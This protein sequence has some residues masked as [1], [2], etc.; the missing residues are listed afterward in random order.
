MFTQGDNQTIAKSSPKISLRGIR[1]EYTKPP[2]MAVR[3]VS[4]DVADGEF[5]AIVGESGSGKSTLVKT[6][7]RLVEPTSGDVLLDGSPASS[8]PVHKL[9]RSIGYMLQGV[10]LFPHYNIFQNI[11]VVLTL[12]KW[13]KSKLEHRVFDVMRLVGLEPEVY[14]HRF[15]KELSGGQQQRAGFAR[16]IAAR[17][18]ILLMDEPLGAIDPVTRSDLQVELHQLHRQLCLTSI[19]VTH[20]MSEAL[21][22][23]DRIAVMRNGSIIEV[24]T[25]FTLLANS[26]HE[27][28][29]RLLNV[30]R[31]QAKQ[32]D[33]LTRAD[34]SHLL[35]MNERSF[36]RT[37]RSDG[38]VES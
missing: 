30:P 14:R 10:G 32:I 33:E 20:D 36:P 38:I 12:L 15:P 17:P 29:K 19:L 16:A 34:C 4:L 31:T 22:L 2:C 11:A 27:Y 8:F 23:A 3:D 28:V 9:R 18:S 25:P 5:M 6:I 35:A 13:E 21:L 7:N 26:E 37:S 1:V 24:G